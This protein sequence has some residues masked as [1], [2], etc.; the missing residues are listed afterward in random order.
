MVED[1]AFKVN[2][3]MENYSSD[4]VTVEFTIAHLR[5]LKKYN[6]EISIQ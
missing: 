3:A 6:S 1:G 2:F 4:Q 5:Q